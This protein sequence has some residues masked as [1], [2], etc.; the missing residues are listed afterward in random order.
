[1]TEDGFEMTFQVNYLSHFLLTEL[2]LPALRQSKPS[3]V[4]NVAST[5]H[6]L[7]CQMMG[8]SLAI[9]PSARC[10]R[11]WQSHL[12]VR[13]PV[14]GTQPWYPQYFEGG[15][16]VTMYGTTKLLNSLH[17]QVLAEREL[18][19]GL[20]ALSVCPG[21]VWSPLGSAVQALCSEQIMNPPGV[22]RQRPCPYTPP[23]GAAV[24]AYAALHSDSNGKWLV[25]YRDCREKSLFMN[26]FSDSDPHQIYEQSLQWVGLKSN[27]SVESRSMLV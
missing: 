15:Q 27:A 7:S 10:F 13:S 17:A 6:V 19:T 21:L 14:T 23:V 2:L 11:D 4:V 12:P 8:W 18:G 3:R 20:T 24:I 26:G 16:P 22:F 5:A 25:R 1:M 9:P